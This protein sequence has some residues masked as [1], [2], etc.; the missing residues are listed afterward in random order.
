VE[1]YVSGNAGRGQEIPT[2]PPE[3]SDVDFR[4]I[5]LI[6]EVALVLLTAL[7]LVG[8][9]GLLGVRD[10]TVSAAAKGYELR[11]EHPWITRGGLDADLNLRVRR[12]G[13][14]TRPV[15]IAITKEYMDRFEVGDILPKPVAQT[16]SPPHVYLSFSPPPADILEVFLPARTLATVQEAGRHDVEVF[17]LADG[18]RPV[19]TEFHTWVV[20]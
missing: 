20:P 13:G 17:V 2:L 18:A 14:F 7:V 11:V 3:L 1:A 6:R 4:R 19:R 5:R 15:T 8:V 12:P 9:T 16:G 10:A